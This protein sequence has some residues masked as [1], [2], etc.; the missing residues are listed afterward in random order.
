MR[1]LK[2]LGCAVLAVRTAAGAARAEQ[3]ADPHLRALSPEAQRLIDEAS[4]QSSIVRGLVARLDA[5]DVIVYVSLDLRLPERTRGQLRFIARAGG[6][7]YLDVRIARTLDRR[8]DIASLGHEIQHALEIAA[9]PE[10]VDAASLDRFYGRVGFSVSDKRW[11]ESHAALR[12]GEAILRELR[13]AAHAAGDE[14][15]KF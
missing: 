10:V 7:R 5:T 13:T 4:E 6:Q 1:V 14:H 15:S 12:A 11:H 3:A 2:S 9:A 8:S